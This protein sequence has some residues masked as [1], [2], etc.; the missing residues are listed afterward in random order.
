[1]TD[2]PGHSPYFQYSPVG[3]R[4]GPSGG[5]WLTYYYYEKAGRESAVRDASHL[6]YDAG[7]GMPELTQSNALIHYHFG[8]DGCPI[9]RTDSTGKTIYFSYGLAGREFGSDYAN[10]TPV[11]Y[12]YSRAE[13]GKPRPAGSGL[14]YWNYGLMGRLIS[15]QGPDDTL[16]YFWYDK[17]DR[18]RAI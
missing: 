10:M 5:G 13:P 2:V 15:R 12:D 7:L 17:A 11:Y 16:T 18:H 3:G 14:A 1:M 8:E 6:K 4:A 9:A